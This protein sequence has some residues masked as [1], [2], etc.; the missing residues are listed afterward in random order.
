M[1]AGS[2]SVRVDQEDYMARS[3]RCSFRGPDVRWLALSLLSA[4]PCSAQAQ[5]ANAVLEWNRLTSNAVVAAA[6]NSVPQTRTFAMVHTAVHDA[7]NAIDRRY[8]PYA[9]GQL[10]PLG[11][12]PEAAVAAAAHDVLVSLFSAQRASLD[13][14]YAAALARI[15]DGQGKTAGIGAGQAAASA[16]IALRQ[17]DRAAEANRP[18]EPGTAPGDYQPTSPNAPMVAPGWGEVTPWAI[19]IDQFRFKTRPRL[20]VDEYDRDV[21]EVQA[22]GSAQ[23]A[24]R[25]TDQTVIARFW[26][27]ATSTMWNRIGRTAATERA[28]GLWESGR[29]FATLSLALADA[30]IC[31]FEAKYRLNFWRPLTAIRAADHDGNGDTEADPSWTSLLTASNHPEYPSAHSIQ[32]AAAAEVLAEIF[33]DETAFEATSLNLPNVTRAFERFSQAS[34]E[35]QLSRIYGGIHF[36]T[37]VEDA[38]RMGR[39]IGRHVEGRWLEAAP[40]R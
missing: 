24:R 25:T 23:N 19:T 28:L 34:E 40:F 35:N 22:I 14:A 26:A 27:E 39:L 16:I 4:A 10:A 38:A 9:G 1:L 32:G 36:R 20:N 7:L 30:T 17:F 12:S 33:G 29:L 8:Q 15:A 2:A 18:Y 6:Q 5:D 3:R 11:A 21:G 13:A 37:A 31:V